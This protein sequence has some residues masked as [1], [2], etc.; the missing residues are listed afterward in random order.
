[1]AIEAV[2]IK[3]A[4]V[5]AKVDPADTS[6]VLPSDWNAAEL[7]SGG[8]D[9][10]M[11][12]KDS[13]QTTGAGWVDGPL[14]QRISDAFTGNVGTTAPLSSV[15]VAFSSNG[16]ILLLPSV[17]VTLAAGSAAILSIR[18]NS[19]AISTGAI[20]ANST[21]I[22]PFTGLALEVS[23]TYTYEL[24]ITGSSGNVTNVQTVLTLLKIGKL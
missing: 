19:V 14:I 13:T 6:L 9:G 20:L 8:S 15:S 11:I 3:H 1:M 21:F 24:I 7:L 17:L 23:G 4:K 16:Y 10:R 5:S 18:R 2:N 22:M 12:L